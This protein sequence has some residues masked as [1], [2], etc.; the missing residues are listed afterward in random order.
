MDQFTSA[1]GPRTGFVR[2]EACSA[3]KTALNSKAIGVVIWQMVKAVLS[4]RT[5]TSMKVNGTMT[6]RM[7]KEF[8][9]T[10]MVVST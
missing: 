6:K 7:D 10:Q 8:T 4:T 5:G 2:A 3:G 1:A 9:C